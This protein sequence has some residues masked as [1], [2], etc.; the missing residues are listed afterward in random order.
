M[1][2]VPGMLSNP[3]QRQ[4]WVPTS[5]LT[6][7]HESSPPHLHTSR[8]QTCPDSGRRERTQP[9]SPSPGCHNCKRPHST[10]SARTNRCPRPAPQAPCNLGGD[11]HPMHRNVRQDRRGT[12]PRAVLQLHSGLAVDVVEADARAT[13]VA[14]EAE[15]P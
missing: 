14:I 1:S 9:S 2:I 8:T 4:P 10:T 5:G 6:F 12:P 15:G 3:M 11:Y 13:R 7:A